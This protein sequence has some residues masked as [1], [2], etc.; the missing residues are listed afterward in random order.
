MNESTR[1]EEAF[2]V[3]SEDQYDQLAKGFVPK[4]TEKCTSWAIN[5]FSDWCKERN[6]CFPDREQCP[7]DLLTK[8]PYDSG[9]LCHWLCRFVAKTQQ[10]NGTKYPATTLYQLLCGVNHFMR[11]V[12]AHAPNAIDQKIPDFKELHCTMD[13]IFRSLLV[14][15]VGARVKHASVITRE[16]E[17][18]LWEQGVLN[19]NNPLGLLRAVFYSNGKVFF[20]WEGNEHRNLK[21]SHFVCQ[22][23][24]DRYIYTENGSKN[25]S[26]GFT[27]LRIENKIVPIY[28]NS[29]AGIR[30]HVLNLIRFA[31]A[32]ISENKLGTMV[33]DMFAEVGIAGKTNH[34]LR[35]TGATNTANVPEKMIQQRTRH[36]SL[37][38]LRTY[39]R[40]TVEQEL[41]V[42]KILITDKNINYTH[43]LPSEQSKV[44]ALTQQSPASTAEQP[45][46]LAPNHML[47]QLF[48]ARYPKPSPLLPILLLFLVVLPIVLSV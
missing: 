34:S 6:S 18:L 33:K 45:C 13:S 1:F 3:A 35:A 43:S 44:G 25:R 46:N 4:N 38:A 17:N 32:P 12:D 29:E 8:L 47:K 31:A 5:N 26:G 2:S 14:K 42:S 27:D 7:E 30:C 40:T 41:A 48:Q 36:R 19:L 15:G 39:E 20:L 21:I 11:S 23:D 22:S 16:E 9:Q 28:A 37:K 10:K 24:P